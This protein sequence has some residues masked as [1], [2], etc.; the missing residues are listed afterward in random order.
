MIVHS[1]NL[2]VMVVFIFSYVK[3]QALPCPRICS[4]VC[5]LHIDEQ[6]KTFLYDRV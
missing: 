6:N 1:I 2:R 4:N 3:S 5:Y